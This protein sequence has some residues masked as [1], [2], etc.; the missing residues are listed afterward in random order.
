V[1]GLISGL[2]SGWGRSGLRID[3]DDPPCVRGCWR[4][5]TFK[6]AT[7]WPALP[8]AKEAAI[9]HAYSRMPFSVLVS[10]RR[11]FAM[12]QTLYVVASL[13]FSSGSISSRS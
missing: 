3:R 7:A 12:Y 13:F 6:S 9:F 4:S 2:S 10:H 1:Q 8:A 11:V 5:T